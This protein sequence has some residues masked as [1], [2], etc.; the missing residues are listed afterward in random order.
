VFQETRQGRP[1]TVIVALVHHKQRRPKAEA[2]LAL[3]RLYII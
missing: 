3:R 1:F 2:G